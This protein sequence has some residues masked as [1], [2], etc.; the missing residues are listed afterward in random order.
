[1]PPDTDPQRQ[2]GQRTVLPHLHTGAPDIPI[3]RRS[4]E[5]LEGLGHHVEEDPFPHPFPDEVPADLFRLLQVICGQ[6][7][8]TIAY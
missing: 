6:P 1:M 5:S 2:S 7:K 3:E 4:R 8:T